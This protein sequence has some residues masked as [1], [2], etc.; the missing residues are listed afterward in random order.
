M[1]VSAIYSSCKYSCDIQLYPVNSMRLPTNR[2]H[3]YTLDARIAMKPQW[4][5]S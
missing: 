3:A 1:S 4:D 5:L 2:P